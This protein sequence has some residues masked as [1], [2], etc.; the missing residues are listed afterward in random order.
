M[1]SEFSKLSGPEFKKAMDQLFH[2]HRIVYDGR[3]W[4]QIRRR[5]TLVVTCASRYSK[6]NLIQELDWIN[7]VLA[8]LMHA[9]GEFQREMATLQLAIV[10]VDRLDRNRRLICTV[11][12][13]SHE[14][15]VRRNYQVKWP[16]SR[17]EVEAR[18]A[19]RKR[20]A[21]IAAIKDSIRSIPSLCGD[22]LLYCC[23]GAIAYFSARYLGSEGI[24]VAVGYAV[25][26]FGLV[27]S[28]ST[29]VEIIVPI[30]VISLPAFFIFTGFPRTEI[31][32]ID[33]DIT[34]GPGQFLQAALI[35]LVLGLAAAL[36]VQI[37][38]KHFFD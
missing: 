10:L 8:D 38:E 16:P 21:K 3:C 23:V 11:Y 29:V 5:N 28:G 4:I 27:S 22:L 30:G 18:R 37:I 26:M 25:I 20:E 9:S 24:A 34:V 1:T 14:D 33:F 15:L 31:M 32:G 13:A 17:E 35:G 7:K 12:A 2:G 36:L 6:D 19:L